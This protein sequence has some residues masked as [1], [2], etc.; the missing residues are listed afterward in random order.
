MKV[1]DLYK[2]KLSMILVLIVITGFVGSL[3]SSLFPN[4]SNLTRN[5]LEEGNSSLRSQVQIPNGASVISKDSQI[6][7]HVF[8]KIN[9][10]I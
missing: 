7:I 3:I 4:L 5:N 10:Q 8:S 9:L 6:L 2:M 1:Q